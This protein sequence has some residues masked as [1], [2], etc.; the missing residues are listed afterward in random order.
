MSTYKEKLKA[1]AYRGATHKSVI[2]GKASFREQILLKH[3]EECGVPEF[4]TPTKADRKLY[5]RKIDDFTDKECKEL[6]IR[7][8]QSEPGA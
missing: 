8:S 2:L 6:W 1:I 3:L 5:Y 7:I 4:I